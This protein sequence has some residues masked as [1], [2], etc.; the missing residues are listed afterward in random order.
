MQIY[1]ELSKLPNKWKNHQ[2]KAHSIPFWIMYGFMAI[3][4]IEMVSKRPSEKKHP[5]LKKK[6]KL[7]GPF[8][9]IATSDFLGVCYFNGEAFS[10]IS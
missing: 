3:G 8:V 7:S 10:T 1:C 6:K 9:N 4:P 5:R 2:I